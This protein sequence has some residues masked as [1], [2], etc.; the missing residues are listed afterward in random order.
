MGNPK[1]CCYTALRGGFVEGPSGL[2]GVWRGPDPL[3]TM[4][5]GFACGV[6]TGLPC[7][8]WVPLKAVRQFN[9]PNRGNDT[10]NA[11][12]HLDVDVDVMKNDSH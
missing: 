10:P 5:T 11:S 1:V 8:I 4:V 12:I 2:S 6:S 7:L 3:L 9:D